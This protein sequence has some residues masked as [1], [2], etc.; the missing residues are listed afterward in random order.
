MLKA[1][2]TGSVWATRRIDSIPRGAWVL[3]R[4]GWSKRTDPAKFLNVKDDGPHAPGFHKTT[5]EL[6][7]K[8][9]D[10]LAR[11]DAQRD[12][13]QDSFSTQHDGDILEGN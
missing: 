6:L 11:S 8:D 13:M 3:L 7:A 12:V 2:V 10:V 9:R 5:S 4:T 1:T